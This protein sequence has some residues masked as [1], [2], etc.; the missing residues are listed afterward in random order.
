MTAKRARKQT[1]RQQTKTAKSIVASKPGLL[2]FWLPVSVFILTTLIF[3][4]DILMSNAFFWEDFVEYVFP[5]QTFAAVEFANGSIPFWNPYSFLGMPF[6]ADLQVGFFYPLNRLLGLFVSNNSLPVLAIESI[7]ILHFLIAQICSYY[8]ARHFRIS[9]Y[10]SIITAISYSFSM[11]LVCHVIHPMMVYH[12]AWLPLILLFFIKGVER[13]KISFSLISGLLLGMTLLSGHPQTTLYIML[14]IGIV[15]LWLAIALI[16]SKAVNGALDWINLVLSG[17]LPVL[18]GIAIFSIQYLPSRELA[19]QSQRSEFTYE[20][21]VEGSLAFKNVYAAV[22]PDIFGKV[23][24]DRDDP[25]TYYNR[26]G[27]NVQT[28]FYWETAFY[29]GIVAFILGF[30]GIF[31]T[32]KS[33]YGALFIFI[34]VFGFLFALGRD[35][36]VFNLLYNLPFF[37]TFRNPA[38]MMF[39][40]IL[41]FSVLAGFGFD[42]I[43]RELKEKSILWTLLAVSAFPL[44][45]ALFTATGTLPEILGAP[46]ETVK[47]ISAS[48]GVAL[49]F[50][51]LVLA[52]SFAMHKGILK[53][54]PSGIV[55]I[56]VAFIDLYIAGSGFNLS[57]QNPGEVYDINPDTKSLFIPKS[58]NDLFRVNTRAYKPVSFMS[59]QRNQGMIDRIMML[60]GYNP[61]VLQKAAI[62]TPDEKSSFDLSNVRYQVS[63]DMEKG[64]WAYAKRNTELP[65]AW[66]VYSA[67][68]KDKSEL[69]DFLRK[70]PVDYRSTVVLTEEP[71]IKLS[72]QSPDTSS[73]EVVCKSY[74]SNEIVYEVRTSEPGILCLS[75]IWYPDWKAYVDGTPAEILEAYYSF[76][77][78]GVPAGKHTVTMRYESESYKTGRLISLMTIFTSIAG[79]IAFYFYEKKRNGNTQVT[80]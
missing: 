14:L 78:I 37:G 48:G 79:I 68:I 10:G 73:Y 59:M 52:V 63:I 17:L 70:E 31:R 61:L 56:L 39:Y 21:S 28:H 64:S 62:Y 35:G 72:G 55:L 3:F 34:A 80:E 75:E 29:F 46:S 53:P 38:R 16:K 33:R 66:M 4:W 41:A 24:G 32:Y 6:L 67:I 69:I 25:S 18:I 57:K 27:G 22:V 20:Q 2:P 15:F 65:R 23:V 49:L 60:E 11:L 19:E 9:S 71:A 30:V 47:D 50:I 12:L 54:V 1:G 7:I 36:A 26:V 8:F 76:R 42:A 45:I 13:S 74:Q 44:L 5:V 77:A 58:E 43:W 40:T 51:G